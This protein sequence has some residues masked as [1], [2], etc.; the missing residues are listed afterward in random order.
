MQSINSDAAERVRA[1]RSFLK[2]ND[3]M[4]YLTMMALRLLELHRGL[5]PA[6]SL[7]L[8]CDQ[9]ATHYPKVLL[10][11]IFGPTRFR[12]E[13]I[14]KRS[15]AHSDGRQGSKHFGRV[16]DTILFYAK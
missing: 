11:G 15:H 10:D 13:I 12:N 16:S 9:T 7:Y 1:M 5:K 8:H 3:M 2:E 6:G 14:W 4:A